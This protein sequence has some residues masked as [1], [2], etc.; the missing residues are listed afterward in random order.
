MSIEKYLDTFNRPAAKL[1][2]IADEMAIDGI[3]Y[4]SPQHLA[5]E[6]RRLGWEYKNTGKLRV[7]IKPGHTAITA[8]V[9]QPANVRYVVGRIVD[10]VIAGLDSITVK[11]LH[12]AIAA[13][14]GKFDIAIANRSMEIRQRRKEWYLDK[15]DRTWKRFDDKS[16]AQK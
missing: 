1:S 2:T 7:W 13:K 12:N 5:G 14:I 16:D 4:V 6:L 9:S 3:D 10:D 8:G 15:S 11:E